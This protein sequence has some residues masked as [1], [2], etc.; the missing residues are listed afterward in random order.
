M[1][2]TDL[3]PMTARMNRRMSMGWRISVAVSALNVSRSELSGN[4]DI[5]TAEQAR[6]VNDRLIRLIEETEEN[7][8]ELK[9]TRVALLNM[10]RFDF[11]GEDTG[12]AV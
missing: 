1:A 11:D 9:S 7:L 2:A 12:P 4:W 6:A 3:D 8:A 5:Y 10:I